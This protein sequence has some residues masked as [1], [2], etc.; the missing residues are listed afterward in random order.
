MRLTNTQADYGTRA[1]D[2]RILWWAT[3]VVIGVWAQEMSGGLDFLTPGLLLCLQ[4]SRWWTAAWL[5]P[6]LVLMQEGGG[7]LAFGVVIVFYAGL[8]AFFLLARWLLEP[9][10]PL[11][12]LLFSFILAVWSW[13]VVR[14]AV[15]FQELP[16]SMRPLWPLI[17]KQWLAYVLFWVAAMI[18]FRRRP[19]GR[20]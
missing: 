3:Y 17:G 4:Y 15:S 2:P 12:I 7:N 18:F 14:G 10:N 5:I 1:R 11:F 20:I 9:E 16:V 13:I 19:H 6:L 8:I